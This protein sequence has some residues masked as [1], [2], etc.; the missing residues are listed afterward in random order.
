MFTCFSQDRKDPWQ[1]STHECS[2]PVLPF[3]GANP[4][5][6][7]VSMVGA[8][9]MLGSSCDKLF[10]SSLASLEWRLKELQLLSNTD[11]NMHALYTHA[12]SKDMLLIVL[13]L[14]RE[15]IPI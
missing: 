14:C 6:L 8:D 11:V 3:W 12:E 2:S 1:G 15:L 13:L 5:I 7:F 4:G 9:P 10:V